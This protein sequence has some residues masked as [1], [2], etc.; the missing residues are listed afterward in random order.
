[1]WPSTSCITAVVIFSDSAQ[2][3]CRWII[4]V[5]FAPNA[6]ERR[7]R[8]LVISRLWECEGICACRY[9]LAWAKLHWLPG[10]YFLSRPYTSLFLWVLTVDEIRSNLLA[11]AVFSSF[12]CHI[13]TSSSRSYVT[14]ADAGTACLQARFIHISAMCFS[15]SWRASKA[16]FARS[17]IAGR[18]LGVSERVCT[19]GCSP[20]T[21]V[22]GA[23]PSDPNV[24]FSTLTVSA[25]LRCLSAC[26]VLQHHQFGLSW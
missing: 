18:F 15:I 21:I 9:V 4:S 6:S 11:N 23:T 3:S 12:S 8:P 13:K 10:P 7:R 19:C 16:I 26:V 2:E 24:S 14:L 1:M 5:M 25:N 17:S 20:N 22:D